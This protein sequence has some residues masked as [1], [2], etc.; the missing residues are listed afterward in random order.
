M[1]TALLLALCVASPAIAEIGC[2]WDTATHFAGDADHSD[3]HGPDAPEYGSD[4][5]L[6]SDRDTHCAFSHGHGDLAAPGAIATVPARVLGFS[7]PPMA[8]FVSSHPPGLD[9]PPRG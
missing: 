8:Q 7:L 4:A 2:S 1:L 6:D 3:E 9:R 5:D